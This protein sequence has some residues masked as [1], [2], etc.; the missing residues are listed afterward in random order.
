MSDLLSYVECQIL[1]DPLRR[2][3]LRLDREINDSGEM[4]DFQHYVNALKSW[5]SDADTGQ[6]ALIGVHSWL[7][8]HRLENAR[9]VP[10]GFVKNLTCK[11]HISLVCEVFLLIQF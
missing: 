2:T 9:Y 7:D 8:W 3:L 6:V 10:S 1:N 5:K 11:I 4:C